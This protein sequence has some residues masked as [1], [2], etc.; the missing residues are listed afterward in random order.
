MSIKQLPKVT[1]RAKEQMLNL[2]YQP[3]EAG[4]RRGPSPR[5][6][7]VSFLPPALARAGAWG[8]HQHRGVCPWTRPLQRGVPVRRHSPSGLRQPHPCCTCPH[9]VHLCAGRDA[10]LGRAMG[11]DVRRQWHHNTRDQLTEKSRVRTRLCT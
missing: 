10:C 5:R 4:F 2:T 9:A 11:R 6:S 7:S 1:Q 8:K 3:G